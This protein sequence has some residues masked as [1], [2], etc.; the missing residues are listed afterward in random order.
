MDPRKSADGP[1][2]RLET[3]DGPERTPG[4]PH[5]SNGLYGHGRGRGAALATSDLHRAD[6]S[7][8]RGGR[9]LTTS[10]LHHT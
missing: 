5:E 9:A 8:V 10:D 4:T 2:S 6:P 3:L 1:D 7:H